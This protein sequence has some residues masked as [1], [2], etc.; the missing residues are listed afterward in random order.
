M[1]D[2]GVTRAGDTGT[3]LLS[4][5]YVAKRNTNSVPLTVPTPTPLSLVGHEDGRLCENTNF[6]VSQANLQEEKLS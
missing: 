5:D 4:Q 6:V 3:G 1:G 2:T